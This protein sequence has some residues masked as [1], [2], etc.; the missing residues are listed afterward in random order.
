M[1]MNPA[2]NSRTGGAE[3]PDGVQEVDTKNKNTPNTD[4]QPDDA[5]TPDSGNSG[6]GT[7]SEGAMKQTSKTDAERGSGG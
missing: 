4:M 1:A 5:G 3:P 6:R 7:A 2:S